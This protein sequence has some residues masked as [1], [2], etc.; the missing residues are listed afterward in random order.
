[1]DMTTHAWFA[2][3]TLRPDQ[4]AQ[5]VRSEPV[6]YWPLGLLE[7][8]SWQLPVGFDGIKAERFCQRMAEHTGG[9][10]LPV[11]WWGGLGGHGDFLWTFYQSEDAARAIVVNTV[12]H[13]ITFGFRAIV[14][15]MG[16]YP[17]DQIVGSQ[18]DAIQQQHP[19]TLILWGTEA[20]IGRPDHLLPGDH[21]AREETSYGLALLPE[22]VD[23]SAM[24]AGRDI[25]SWPQAKPAQEP[26]PNPG[27]N[28]D[29][30]DPL[31]AQ[32]GTDARLAT[33]ERGERALG[34][35]IDLLAERV[36]QHLEKGVQ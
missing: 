20:S 27:V 2:Y 23:M 9:V 25:T 33:A 15:L 19:E 22:L 14:L 10:I 12:E 34:P 4:L 36:N 28:F 31:F 24:R 13:L 26:Q 17:W 3:E 21:A 11:M 35:L 1:M 7:H 8:H 5:V 16:H 29:P 32:Y 18:L 30:A 6:A